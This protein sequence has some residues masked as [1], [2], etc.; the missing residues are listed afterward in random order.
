MRLSGGIDQ[1]L[2]GVCFIGTCPYGGKF[3][4]RG[5]A[6]YVSIPH[7]DRRF[8][9]LVTARH[10]IED[11][12]EAIQTIH[13]RVNLKAGATALL[14]TPRQKWT[15][16]PSARKGHYVDVAVLPFTKPNEVKLLH[17]ILETEELTFEAMQKDNIGIGC[18]TFTIGLFTNHYGEDRN[19]PV[20]RFGHLSMLSQEPMWTK[21]GYMDGHLVEAHSLGGSSGSPVFVTPE[22]WQVSKE[23]MPRLASSREW[24]FI[25][26]ISGHWTQEN[27]EDAIPNTTE[28]TPTGAINT[29]MMIVVPVGKIKEALT[30]RYELETRQ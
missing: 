11:L 26:L 17:M 10:V 24:Y 21:Y 14:E 30:H 15:F 8:Y 28:K 3:T 23:G 22:L 20:A 16:H 27:P 1:V 29:G 18:E 4:P 6:F 7:L 19:F 5:T 13:I 25:G 9:Q 12:D 2:K